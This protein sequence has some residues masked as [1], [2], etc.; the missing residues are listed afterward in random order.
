VRFRVSE[1]FAPLTLCAGLLMTSLPAKAQTAPD[2]VAALPR[3]LMPARALASMPAG[4]FFENLWVDG[5]GSLLITSYLGR[6]ILRWRTAVG[7]TV[8]ARIDGHPASIASDSDGTRYVAVHGQS[9]RVGAAMLESQRI[10]RLN[11]DGSTETVLNAPQAKFFN[12]MAWLSPGRFLIADSLAGTIWLLDVHAKSLMPWLQHQDLESSLPQRM[13]PGANGIHIVGEQVWI[14]NSSRR[15][16]MTVALLPDFTA[17][18]LQRRV[19]GLPIDDFA[20]AADG[21]ILAATHRQAVLRL[22]LD[23]KHEVIAESADVNDSTAVRFGRGAEA[24]KAYVVTSGGAFAGRSETVQLVQL[25]TGTTAA[26]E[27]EPRR[28]MSNLDMR[29]VLALKVGD[30]AAQKWLPAP[31]R[32]AAVS[33]GPAQGSNLSLIFVDRQQVL[34]EAGALDRG[35]LERSMIVTVPARHPLT[36]ESTTFPIRAYSTLAREVPGPYG[37]SAAAA[38]SRQ[39]SVSGEPTGASLATESWR[40]ATPDGRSLELTVAGQIGMPGRVSAQAALRSPTQPAFMRVYR[41][42]QAVDQWRSAVAGSSDR[43]TTLQLRS[44]IAELMPLLGSQPQ[45]LS[46]AHVPWYQRQVFIP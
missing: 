46:V 42:E 3:A 18:S 21:S 38:I 36:G 4:N 43:V 15:L 45:V 9:F 27:R 5:D 10:V 37:T 8:E 7:L 2:P 25:D 29:L 40:V 26:P 32:V 11:A 41:I 44:D 31:W 33:T 24:G 39:A 6:E 30:E 34:D 12:G 1:F 13:V 17:G 22:R 16:L 35:G 19:E 23:G 20:L 14:S 28:R